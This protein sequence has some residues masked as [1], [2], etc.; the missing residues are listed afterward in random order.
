MEPIMDA[1]RLYVTMGEMCDALRDVWGSWRE[2][3]VF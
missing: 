2:T 1:S 3:P